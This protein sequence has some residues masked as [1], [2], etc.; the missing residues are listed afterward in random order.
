MQTAVT[1][2][3]FVLPSTPGAIGT[4]HA[5]CLASIYACV[6]DVD[7]NVALAYTVVIHLIGT[8]GPG[9]PGILILPVEFQRL[10]ETLG[11]AT[12]P[13]TG[14]SRIMRLR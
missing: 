13:K 7:P 5:L 3:T 14:P 4:F 12:C 9:L 11:A 2:L 8:L 6:P 1:S 10:R